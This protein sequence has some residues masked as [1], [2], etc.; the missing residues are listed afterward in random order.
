MKKIGISLAFFIVT[1]LYLT[2]AA[3]GEEKTEMAELLL[4]QNAHDVSVEKGKLTLK[5]VSPTT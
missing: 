2:L 1:M 4:V 5:K 3:Y